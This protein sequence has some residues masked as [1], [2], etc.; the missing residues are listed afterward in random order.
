MVDVRSAYR[1]WF[2]RRMSWLCPGLAAAVVVFVRLAIDDSLELW[3]RLPALAISGGVTLLFVGLTMLPALVLAAGRRRQ[4]RRAQLLRRE[5]RSYPVLALMSLSLAFMLLAVPLLFGPHAADR[6]AVP[7]M[8]AG[9]RV[10]HPAAPESVPAEPSTL[11]AIPEIPAA[12]APTAPVPAVPEPVKAPDPVAAAPEPPPPLPERAPSPAPAPAATASLEL[13]SG[14]ELFSLKFRPDD[15]D[16]L[17]LR[18]AGTKVKGLDRGGLPDERSA[19]EAPLPRVMLDITIVPQSQGW[20]GA[21]YEAGVAV[22]TWKDGS[23]R[24]EYFYGSLNDNVDEV[25]FEATMAWHRM[26][27]EVEQR[28]AGYTRHATF[29]LAVRAGVSVDR[30]ITG[31]TSLEVSSNPRP[32]PRIGI[33][34]AIWGQD[35]LGLVTEASHTFALRVDGAASSVTDLKVQ[36]RIDLS[37][38]TMFVIGYRY[39]AVRI[40]DQGSDGGVP[41]QELEHSFS[42]PMAGLTVAF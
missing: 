25:E 38:R 36:L 6:I 15:D 8:T 1:R 34:V 12:Q 24:G 33:E 30:F 26:T 4:S 18:D 17:L 11:A 19:D 40:H 42:G 35:G 16:W 32:S 28:L 22:P 41:F 31:D 9:P 21:F 13:P 14:Q 10:H 29:D 23:I 27:V 7:R 3:L 2:W 5:F 37:E 20:Y 39:V